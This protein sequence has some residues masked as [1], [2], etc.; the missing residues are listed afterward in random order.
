MYGTTNI[1][2]CYKFIQCKLIVIS[3]N[4]QDIR[5]VP[6]S[7]VLVSPSSAYREFMYT[8]A[9]ECAYSLFLINGKL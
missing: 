6:S 4:I 7:S 8:L 5:L 9:W 3:N 1:K 2:L